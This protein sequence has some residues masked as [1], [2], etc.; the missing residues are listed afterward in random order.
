MICIDD[1]AYKKQSLVILTECPSQ[2]DILWCPQ[3]DFCMIVYETYFGRVIKSLM[4][5]NH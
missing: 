5:S 1:Y 2:K 4:K 3:M